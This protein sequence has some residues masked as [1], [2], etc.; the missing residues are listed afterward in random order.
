[1]SPLIFLRNA[2]QWI[3][4][5]LLLQWMAELSSPSHI[6]YTLVYTAYLLLHPRPKRCRLLH[7]SIQRRPPVTAADALLHLST[8]TATSHGC[9]CPA[10]SQHRDG[11]LSSLPMPCSISAPRRPPV[12]AADALLSTVI[13]EP[14]FLIMC[15]S[16]QSFLYCWSSFLYI[17]FYVNSFWPGS[18]K[19]WTDFN[20]WCAKNMHCWITSHWNEKLHNHLQGCCR[21]SIGASCLWANMVTCV[22]V[23]LRLSLQ[24]DFYIVL[25]VTVWVIRAT[26]HHVCF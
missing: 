18:S 15:G 16:Q 25:F 19:M 2:L 21:H 3:H 22:T 20:C 12:T 13:T 7:L 24:S 9:W 1:M 10:P 5:V 8:A 17:I 14:R 23:T 11:H 26:R 4:V 6:F